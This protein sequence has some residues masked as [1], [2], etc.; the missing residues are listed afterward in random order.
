MN[1]TTVDALLVDS[2]QTLGYTGERR[3]PELK[4]CLAERFRDWPVLEVLQR[5]ATILPTTRAEEE[6]ATAPVVDY[7]THGDLD[8]N[9]QLVTRSALVQKYHSSEQV[10]TI[11][12]LLVR[13]VLGLP[14]PMVFDGLVILH[15]A[16]P[17]VRFRN[18]TNPQT[19][20]TIVV[21][22]TAT[23][24]LTEMVRD[25]IVRYYQETRPRRVRCL[26][27]GDNGGGASMWCAGCLA[28]A[29]LIGWRLYKTCREPTI[30]ASC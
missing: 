17:L 5:S 29:G 27:R 24:V 6:A 3:P 7:R 16:A 26:F 20:H 12:R 15:S 14:D 8:R 1:A 28:L 30:V 13:P 25:C 23:R 18:T 9:R 11:L 22:L 19:G 10:D 4:E 21:E 2:L